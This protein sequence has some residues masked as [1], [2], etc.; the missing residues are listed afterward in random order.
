M[1][2]VSFFKTHTPIFPVFFILKKFYYDTTNNMKT[3][4]NYNSHFF[5]RN[6][7]VWERSQRSEDCQ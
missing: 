1:K 6:E 4:F 7:G 2:F 5:I 3:I